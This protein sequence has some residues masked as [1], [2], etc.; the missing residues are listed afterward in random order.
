MTVEAAPG[1]G[2]TLRNFVVVTGSGLLGG[3]LNALLIGLAARRGEI[4]EIAAYT[5]ISA[6]LAVVAV[7]VGGGSSTMLYVSGTEEERVAIRSQRVMV[8]LP[9]L[10]LTALVAIFV[11]RRL[12]YSILALVATALVFMCNSFGELPLAQ[13]YR[14]LRFIRIPVPVVLSKTVTLATFLLGAPLTTA[15]LVGAVS[16]IVVIELLTGKHSTLSA[17]RHS[18]PTVAAARRAFRSGRA[19]Y[20]YSLA[21]L[22][23]LK[24]PSVGLSLVIPVPVMGAFGAVA[25][26]YQALLT[27]FQSGLYM[28]LSLRSRNR[29]EQDTASARRHH[30]ETLSL[31]TGVLCALIIFVVAA[32]L[33]TSVLRLNMPEAATWLRLFGATVPFVLI[34]RIIAMRAIADG[35]SAKAARIIVSLAGLTTV[36]LAV[37]VPLLGV[38]GGVLSTFFAE[39]SVA[40][41]LMAAGL[42]GAAWSTM[43]VTA[44][45][46]TG[47]RRR[48]PR[49]IARRGRS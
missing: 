39:V 4:A 23:A 17:L 22:Y 49:V 28:V 24:A 2:M 26:V 27:V 37:A 40:G 33:T 44:T 7:M 45:D 38:T 35:Q 46:R 34:N 11:Y 32:R 3:L 15:L 42:S 1:R 47:S 18:A 21:E 12:D 43:M 19:L 10:A 30:A 14:D 29:S 9:A 8:V 36:S 5:A 41:A 6:L 31:F 13:L 16:N 20:A 48:R 25:V